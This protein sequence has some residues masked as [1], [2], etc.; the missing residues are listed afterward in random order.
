MPAPWIINDHKF[1]PKS[2]ADK[3]AAQDRANAAK[4]LTDQQ[5]NKPKGGGGGLFSSAIG[6]LGDIASGGYD[7]AKDAANSDIARWD[8]FVASG[9]NTPGAFKARMDE[10]SDLAM[11]GENTLGAVGIDSS[12]LPDSWRFPLRQAVDV[13]LAPANFIGLGLAGKGAK[14]AGLGVKGIGSVIGRQAVKD[15]AAGTAGYVGAQQVDER[16]PENTPDIVRQGIGLGTGIAVGGA[17]YKGAHVVPDALKGKGPLRSMGGSMM[18][19]VDPETRML[20]GTYN[21]IPEG[22]MLT[23]PRGDIGAGAYLTRDISPNHT[24]ANDYIKGDLLNLAGA[25]DPA[26]VEAGAPQVY[27]FR[28]KRELFLLSDSEPLTPL[29]KRSIRNNLPEVKG[30]TKESVQEQFDRDTNWNGSVVRGSDARRFL[31]DNFGPEEFKDTMSKAGFDGMVDKVG[32]TYQHTIFKPNEVLEPSL[33]DP[34]AQPSKPLAPSSPIGG[35]PSNIVDNTLSKLDSNNSA[36]HDAN[37]AAQAASS[38]TSDEAQ[39]KI[40]TISE[41][42]ASKWG[43][44]YAN[45][46]DELATTWEHEGWAG[47]ENSWNNLGAKEQKLFLENQSTAPSIIHGQK[48]ELDPTAHY[49]YITNKAGNVF[50]PTAAHNLDD[51]KKTWQKL[52]D[53][54]AEGGWSKYAEKQLKD[55]EAA[56]HQIEDGQ[57]NIATPISKKSTTSALET[58]KDYFPNAPEYLLDDYIQAQ[59]NYNF[60][61]NFQDFLEGAG[62]SKSIVKNYILNKYS[63]FSPSLPKTGLD[64]P[65]PLSEGP[66]NTSGKDSIVYSWVKEDYP[67]APEMEVLDYVH[68]IENEGFSG[69]FKEYLTTKGGYDEDY[70]QLKKW[71]SP[72][73]GKLPKPAADLDSYAMLQEE[74]P[75][76]S[77]SEL[78][79]FDNAMHEGYE[80]SFDDFL[81]EAGY[82]ETQIKNWVKPAEEVPLQVPIVKGGFKTNEPKPVSPEEIVGIKPQTSFEDQLAAMPAS[83]EHKTYEPVGDPNAPVA[84]KSKPNISGVASQE[85][86]AADFAKMSTAQKE[87]YSKL[88]AEKPQTHAQLMNEVKYQIPDSAPA[89]PPP[90]PSMFAKKKYGTVQEQLAAKP[91]EFGADP[92]P[93]TDS[94]KID[95]TYI[96]PDL[97]AANNADEYSK[98]QP[99]QQKIYDD[100]EGPHSYKM[101]V[102]KAYKEISG[103]A[104]PESLVTPQEPGIGLTKGEK[105]GN[106]LLSIQ[107]FIVGHG[108]LNNEIATPIAK[109]YNRINAV[110]KTQATN[111][112]KVAQLAEKIIPM[113]ENLNINMNNLTP[114]QSSVA[115]ALNRHVDNFKATLNEHGIEFKDVQDF[116]DEVRSNATGKDKR[117]S[118]ILTEYGNAIAGKV[119]DK[120]LKGQIDT[121]SSSIKDANKL[122]IDIPT[123]SVN[124]NGIS[125][126]KLPPEV[127]LVLSRAVKK[128]HPQAGSEAGQLFNAVNNAFRNLWA[129]G[130]LSFQFIQNLPTLVDNPKLAGEVAKLTMQS[131][132]D[133]TTFAKWSIQHDNQAYGVRPTISRWIENEL[134]IA[135]DTGVGTDIEGLPGRVKNLPG[136]GKLIQKSDTAF[137][138]NGNFTRVKLADYLYDNWKNHGILNGLDAPA[139]ASEAE[140]MRS[141][142][143]AANRSTGYASSGFGGS[144]GSATLFAPRFLQSQLETLVKAFTDGGIEG[145]VARRQMIKLITIGSGITVAANAARGEDTIFDPRDSNFMRIRNVKGA[146]LSVFGPWDSL[147]RGLVRSVPH[148]EQNGDFTLGDPSYMVRSKLSPVLSIGVDL[149]K[150]ENVIGD[151]VAPELPTS[152]DAIKNDA[153]LAKNTTLPFALRGIGDEPAVV[154][155]AGFVG[156]KGAPLT[157]K[158]ILKNTLTNNGIKESD[159]DYLIK[160]REYL[161]AHPDDIPT[162]QGS[163][164]DAQNVQQDISARRKLNDDKVISGAQSLAQF[165]DNRKVLLQEQRDKLSVLIKDPPSKVANTDQEKWLKSYFDIFKQN[166]DPIT[167]T[168]DAQSFDKAVADWTNKNGSAA[169]NF[170]NRY[171]GAGLNT[172]ESSYFNDLRKLDAAGYF[173]M[174]QYRGMKSDL[175]EKEID[176]I[177]QQVDSARIANPALQKQSIAQTTSDLFKGHL[178]SAE[179][180]DVVNAGKQAYQNPEIQ[181]FKD[182]HRKELMW[183]N[184]KADWNAY[185]NANNKVAT[186][187]GSSSG[188]KLTGLQLKG[189]LK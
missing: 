177:K 134:H 89:L 38:K 44:K 108:V 51:L 71:L 69:G 76:A 117:F 114:A 58:A 36:E 121:I 103:G 56:V 181:K 132:N 77:K 85:Q 107:K 31:E 173:K 149:L 17:V 24:I 160:K 22:E 140:V 16:L 100:V 138:E 60:N 75:N 168:I 161:A 172:A 101:G 32:D 68:A 96:E 151:K 30:R 11:S 13:G 139:G 98:L 176:N 95:K 137:V 148:I 93:M 27:G 48:P 164:K 25:H 78:K 63:E 183:F 61:G 126:V 37:K 143:K 4:A 110:L 189:F 8:P 150:G 23:S 120:W 163:Y 122:G 175:T 46:F 153:S 9:L 165:R 66:P 112:G 159:P 10:T 19:I 145:Q 109:E 64:N 97:V 45:T 99:A 185:T 123:E 5:Y 106:A 188:Y 28:A 88:Q 119:A 178:S 158:E 79:Y 62:Y 125:S 156:M 118:D 169:L 184:P 74:Y 20:H 116:A 131:I 105:V 87:L 15:V 41:E 84:G 72:G 170:V 136:V 47:W 70:Y 83:Y 3:K 26:S 166:Q 111:L 42:I 82:T 53:M 154:S 18:E 14:A 34:N 94:Q 146:D 81:K 65:S 182:S 33:H 104:N 129:T 186:A 29:E 124:V 1:I 180:A 55:V 12:N 179:L 57:S 167:K 171:T 174:K 39:H 21:Y 142:A 92:N 147:L 187:T 113:D 152:I 59:T 128:V 157:G 80:G 6:K 67:H 54:K 141:I 73:K 127:G 115:E 43:N 35:D 40:D 102:A 52:L 130:D 144:L 90:G 2:E 86:I 7:L 133:P 49:G 162:A 135:P 50:N 155:G 91:V